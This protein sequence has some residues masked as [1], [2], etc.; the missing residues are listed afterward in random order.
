MFVKEV[1]ISSFSTKVQIP[2]ENHYI[3]GAFFNLL[4]S[5]TLYKE[6]LYK[7]YGCCRVC[8]MIVAIGRIDKNIGYE[9][10]YMQCLRIHL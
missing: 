2:S 6:F 7:S 4:I 10:I 3:F 9:T 5:F 8:G 1:F